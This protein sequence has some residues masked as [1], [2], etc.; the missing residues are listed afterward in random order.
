[1][2]FVSMAFL[3]G[4]TCPTCGNC[5]T[6]LVIEQNWNDFDKL[7]DTDRYLECRECGETWREELVEDKINE[8]A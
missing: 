8:V 3:S 4:Q 2:A 5:S 6:S 1:M 7:E